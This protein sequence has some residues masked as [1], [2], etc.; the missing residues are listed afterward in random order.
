MYKE[1][2]ISCDEREGRAVVM[3]DGKVMEILIA[4]DDRQ[5]GCIYKGRISNVIPGM[6]AAFVDIGLERNG[7]LCADDALAHLGEDI[8]QDSFKKPVIS[9]I[10]KVNQ[11]VLVQIVKEAIGTKGAR[12]TTYVTL[13]GRYMVLLPSAQYIGVSRRIGNEDERNR[14]R[15]LAEEVRPEG[16]GVIVRTAAEGRSDEELK[17]DMEYLVRLWDKIQQNSQN[18]HA[19]CLVHKELSLVDKI[20]RD[21]FN[22]DIDR[23]VIDNEEE[24]LKMRERLET[25]APA[26]VSKVHLYNDRRP[27]FDMYN[28]EVE[29]DKA[30]SRKVWLESGGYLIVDH[31][32]ALWVIDVNTG[33][34]TGKVSLADTILRTN[35]EACK[36]ICRQLRLRDMAGIIIIDFIDM[37]SMDD[38]QR[39]L[40]YLESELKKDRT[41]TNL[42]SMTELGLVQLTRKREDKDLDGV[43]RE[44]CPICRGRGKILSAESLACRARREILRESVSGHHDSLIVTLAP[45]AALKFAGYNCADAFKLEEELKLTMR[46]IADPSMHPEN[47]Q[48][49]FGAKSDLGDK[50]LLANGQQ[51]RAVLMDMP[52][53]SYPDALAVINGC[54]AVVPNGADRVG[55]EVI[56]RVVNA[57]KFVST[58]E[59]V[60]K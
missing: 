22:E 55:K 18:L 36:E 12:I 43:M 27:L 47:F 57:G 28:V 40:E 58:A 17:G 26:L 42:V 59:I 5:V 49:A 53:E 41:R 37:D 2:L 52:A 10:V 60:K 38:Q 11:E 1:I 33:K 7:F 50:P 4:R 16:M 51:A 6:N 54:L 34:F 29:I 13:P 39:M 3:E 35:M 15:R 9:D 48:I 32:E 14:L 21:I 30:L 25:K 8:T 23:L 20:L 44:L 24:Y 31:T 56:L 19:P 45:L 46:I